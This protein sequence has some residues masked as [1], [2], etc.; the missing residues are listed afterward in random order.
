[1]AF[2]SLTSVGIYGIFLFVQNQ[3]HRGYFRLDDAEDEAGSHQHHEASSRSTPYHALL[4]GA[5]GVPLVLLAKQMSA[6]LDAVVARLGAPVALGGLLLAMLVLTPESIAALRAARDN[7]LQRSI[8]ILLGSALA[9]IGLTIPLVIA[10]SLA[11]GRG[12]VLGLD[13][14]EIVMLLL[15]LVT[16][17]LTFALPLMS[18]LLGCVHLLL[19][20]AYFML[21]F[22]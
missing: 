10:I 9:S 4:L 12:L 11:T 16:A 22:D 8:N 21:I 6:P 13:P 14:A 3:R 2:L 1:M 5:Y 18:M 17:E 19:F 15:T 20:A 7:R